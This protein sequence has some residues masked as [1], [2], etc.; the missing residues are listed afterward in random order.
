MLRENF[1]DF[2]DGVRGVRSKNLFRSFGAKTPTGPYFF[3]FITWTYKKNKTLTL[4]LRREEAKR[5]RFRK[6]CQ[7]VEVIILTIAILGIIRAHRRRRRRENGHAFA[8]LVGERRTS[9]G[10]DLCL[11]IHA[12]APLLQAF[13]VQPS[14]VSFQQTRKD[15]R[16]GPLKPTTSA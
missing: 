8:Y 3:F 5:F 6:P 9:S 15:Y 2:V 14:A 10:I 11:V 12:N 4:M 16:K 1:I 7:I 13:S